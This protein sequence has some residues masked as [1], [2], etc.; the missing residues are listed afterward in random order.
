[1]ED[2]TLVFR[3]I[4]GLFTMGMVAVIY[5]TFVK[6][7]RRFY[8]IWSVGFLLYGVSVCIRAVGPLFL[9]E[10]TVELLAGIPL[11]I[12]FSAIFA[13]LGDLVDKLRSFL[14]ASLIVPIS[15]VVI[16]LVSA[17]STLGW[18]LGITPYLLISGVLVYMRLRYKVEV[19]LLSIGWIFLLVI[20]F[21]IAFGFIQALYG[22]VLA[23]VGKIV[24]LSGIVIPRFTLLA[25][26]LKQFLLSG[27]AETY[28]EGRG[29]GVTLIESHLTREDEIKWIIN[30]VKT[31]QG[32][33]QRT[34]LV[35]THD[36]ISPQQIRQEHL[37]DQDLYIVRMVHGNLEPS[38]LFQDK[39]MSI[40]D[41][42]MELGILLSEVVGFSRDRRIKVNVVLY[43][44]STLIEIHNWKDLH[45]QLLTMIPRLKAARVRIDAFFYPH[46]HDDKVMVEVFENMADEVVNLKTVY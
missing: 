32:G 9:T 30:K 13:G 1:M 17:P 37:K 26:D 7:S 34:I 39:V 22:E 29:G 40:N 23:I 4:N 15:I 36:L 35:T 44:L 31:K 21:G 43:S 46:I 19:D 5:P 45:K 24:V 25:D 28:E 11:M 27:H 6:T 16:Y 41:D 42:L 3:L 14:L 20:N 38:S 12:G 8:M 2:L 33:A 18:I 10:S